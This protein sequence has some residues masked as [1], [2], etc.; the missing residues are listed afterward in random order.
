MGDVKN[1][2][3]EDIKKIDFATLTDDKIQKLAKSINQERNDWKRHE[4]LYTVVDKSY[5]CRMGILPDNHELVS[6]NVQKLML[7]KLF[8]ADFN[9]MLRDIT[10]LIDKSAK[11]L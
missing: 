8:K 3:V 1:L 9:F 5:I 4:L 7:N 11:N 6:S 10:R 2:T